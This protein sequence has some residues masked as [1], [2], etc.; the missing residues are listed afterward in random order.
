MRTAATRTLSACV[1]TNIAPVVFFESA[2]RAPGDYAG[3]M[4]SG[5]VT[6]CVKAAARATDVG[7][8]RRPSSQ[9]RGR[10]LW[11]YVE[12]WT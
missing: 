11:C 8:T 4:P 1:N 7:P 12:S 5:L 10:G 2:L 9:E 3:S 6:N